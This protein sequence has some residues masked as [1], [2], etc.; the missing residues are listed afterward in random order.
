MT[1]PAREPRKPVTYFHASELHY[2]PPE[3][4]AEL[5]MQMRLRKGE[6]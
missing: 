2:W 6:A 5:E 4:V 1:S 3:K